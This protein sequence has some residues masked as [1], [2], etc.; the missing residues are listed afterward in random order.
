MSKVATV[1]ADPGQLPGAERLQRAPA[2]V[3]GEDHDRRR[4]RGLG[5]VD[6]PVPGGELRGQGDHRGHGRAGRGQGPARQHRDLALPPGQEVVV[7]LPRRHRELRRRRHRHGALGHQGQAAGRAACSTCWAAPSTRSCPRSPPA[8]PTTRTSGAMVEEAQ[9]WVAPGLHGVKVG[10]GKRGNARLGYEHDRDVEYMRRMREG[11]GPKALI[12]LD[13]GW[14]VK[15]DVMTAVRRVQAFEEYGLHWI[16]EPLGAW[17][18]EGYANLRGKTTTLIAYGEKE[19]N[20]DGLRAGAGDRHRR[21]RGHRP[22]AAPRASPASRGRPSGS[23]STGARR[24]PTAW[25][26]AICSAASLAISF[27]SPAFK[28]LRGQAAAQPDAARAGDRADRARRRLVLPADQAGPGHRGHRGG[29]RP[30]PQREGAAP[31][32]QSVGRVWHSTRRIGEDGDDGVERGRR[33]RGQGRHR[34]GRGGWHRQGGRARRSRRPA[35]R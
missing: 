24:T 33:P 16:E 20:L 30:L 4:R 7:R 9:E 29:G 2:P 14:N 18:P 17:D 27:S 23:S 22:R 10:L 35:R 8:T 25:S 6:H 12:M 32:R 34:H 15:W 19:W 1:E 26:S 31:T 21:R 5:R 3:P 11:L 28:L 13:C